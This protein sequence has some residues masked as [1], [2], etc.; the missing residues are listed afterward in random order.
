[1]SNNNTKVSQTFAV[2]RKKLG[3]RL[4][5]SAFRRGSSAFRLG[6]M[7]LGV[8]DHLP[9][10][11]RVGQFKP[12]E[13]LSW[14]VLA[15]QHLYNNFM[16][17]SGAEYLAEAL[18]SQYAESPYTEHSIYHF[19]VEIAR[20]L[21]QRQVSG[22]ITIDEVALQGFIESE[23]APSLLARSRDA[24][25]ATQKAAAVKRAR[26]HLIDILLDQAHE[27]AH[28][29]KLALRHALEL[30]HHIEGGGQM[31]WASRLD[32]L[33]SN[34]ALI[35]AMSKAPIMCLQECTKPADIVDILAENGKNMTCLQHR[36]HERTS[37]HCVILFDETRFEQIDEPIYTALESNT[38]PCI[39]VKLRDKDTGE[40]VIV[41][42][43]HHPG[44]KRHCIADIAEH[45]AKLQESPP[46]SYLIAGD[47]NHQASHFAED[48]DHF[49]FPA[50]GTMAGSDYDNINH[51]I[52]CVMS[53]LCDASVSV[54]RLEALSQ[55]RPSD[56]AVAC[57]NDLLLK[58]LGAGDRKPIILEFKQDKQALTHASPSFLRPVQAE[59]QQ[60]VNS[61]ACVAGL[62]QSDSTRHDRVTL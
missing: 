50:E 27:H 3:S 16:N 11:A 17:V 60:D 56:L 32:I 30:F 13:L 51:A 61:Q 57:D 39:F 45:I 42:S 5:S 33:K 23:Q 26:Q 35:D 52:D 34:P 19:F 41:G 40:R 1:M 12:Y 22:K 7:P 6:L 4:A 21:Y 2:A 20:Y 10:L 18:L 44:G 9:I 28:E 54:C 14:N 29:F 38:K 48:K 24:A 31:N 15:D 58:T 43:I 36:I 53:N 8:S 62:G 47:F 46:L 59:V 55:C 49:H 25:T 37:D